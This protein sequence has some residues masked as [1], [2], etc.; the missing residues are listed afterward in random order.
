MARP[1]LDSDRTRLG[2]VRRR[3]PPCRGRRPPSSRPPARAGRERRPA[4]DDASAD[5]TRVVDDGDR[6]QRRT[7]RDLGFHRA[8]RD[9]LRAAADQRQ[10]SPR[11]CALG[12][13]RGGR[14]PRGRRQRPFQLAGA[15]ARRRLRDRRHGRLL[16]RAGDDRAGV[17]L[18]R[19]TR[20]LRPARARSQL[21]AAERPHRSR[22]GAPRRGAE[23][24]GGALAG[25][26]LRAGAPLRRLH[27]RR[28]RAAPRLARVG[29]ARR[30]ERRRGGVPDPRRGGR[31]ARRA[32]GRRR[33]AR[34]L[35]PRRG[36]P[37]R[38]RQPQRLACPRGLP[39]LRGR[40]RADRRAAL[41]EGVP[42]PEAA[43]E[44]APQRGQE[45]RHRA[46]REGLRAAD[47]PLGD[48]LGARRGRSPTGPS[49]TSSSTSAAAR[50]KAQSSPARNTSACEARSPPA[51]WSCAT[52]RVR[53]SSR[54]CTGARTSSRGPSSTRSPIC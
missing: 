41:R 20:A 12:P 7:S 44:A 34:R 10:L 38:R 52:P 23:G 19:A 36:A 26:A 18:R 29:G 6:R 39:H 22:P 21:P 11:A 35:R 4:L 50:A 13:A 14:P 1:A 40:R 16:P 37:R 25:R 15:R 32:R 33:R 46:A 28:P 31:R 2:N 9:R 43:A 8:G 45:P 54:P 42:A 48:R 27:G 3:R 49:A 53:R 24:A 5:A 17:A 30:R 51:R 47:R